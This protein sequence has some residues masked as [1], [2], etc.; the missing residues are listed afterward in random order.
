MYQ[1]AN[2]K[3]KEVYIGRLWVVPPYKTNKFYRPHVDNEDPHWVCLYY[4]N[5]TDGDTLFFENNQINSNIIKRVSPKKGRVV[6]F[7]G[8]LWHCPETPT[9][10]T[11]AVINYNVTIDNS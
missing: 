5:D 2:I 3:F 9:K 11:R 7:D 4:I 1:N 8:S 10:R 6:L